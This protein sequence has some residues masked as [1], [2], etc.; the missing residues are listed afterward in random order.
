MPLD[1]SGSEGEVGSDEARARLARGEPILRAN[2]LVLDWNAFAR[3]FQETCR[4]AARHRASDADEF[5]HL[6]EL[7]GNDPAHS[8]KLAREY[9]SGTNHQLL[10]TNLQSPISNLQS[11]VLNNALHPFLAAFAREHQALIDDAAWYRA[12]C[13]VCGGEPDFAA[14]EKESGAR[15]LLCSRCDTEWTFHRTTCPFCGE[16]EPEKLGYY[17]G[18]HGAY[19]LYTCENCKRYLKTIDLRELAREVNLP[20]ERVLTIGM[21]LAA[22]NAGY[23]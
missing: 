15:R 16:Q 4:V 8:G 7:F 22:A 2:E 18:G 6:A 3:L 21:D 20:G 17:P 14:L 10:I 1:P 19:R 12:D 23:A 13:P 9:I 11:F 5:N